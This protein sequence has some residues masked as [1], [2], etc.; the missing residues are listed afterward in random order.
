MN[1]FTVRIICSD[2]TKEM[3]EKKNELINLLTQDGWFKIIESSGEESVG[4]YDIIVIGFDKGDESE[5]FATV[6]GEEI[7][8][9]Y[10]EDFAVKV[11]RIFFDRWLNSRLAKKRKEAGNET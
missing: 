7:R 2:D 9:K 1:E 8:G 5:I 10:L 6:C 11:H 3:I 4:V